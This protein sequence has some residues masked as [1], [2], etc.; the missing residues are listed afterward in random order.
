MSF[1][2][3]SISPEARV[4]VGGGQYEGPTDTNGWQGIQVSV[5]GQGTL[6]RA[7]K[8][9]SGLPGGI[10]KAVR[11]AM[12]RSVSH[13]RAA[14]VKAIRDRYAIAA[15]NVRANENVTVRY[16]YQNGVQATVN[17]AGQ[18]I[19]L[20]RFDGAS[21]KTPAWDGA[22]L[23]QAIVSGRW[24]TVHPGLPASGHVLKSTSPRRFQSA[25]VATMKTG[26]TGIFQ[27]TGG[28]TSSG[29]D[30]LD[31]FYGPSIPQML[32]SE[33]VEERLA[34]ETMEQFDQRLE[35]EVSAILN[36]WR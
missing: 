12:S 35:H 13:L 14:N 33:A 10:N 29:G 21:P 15:A 22:S 2:D 23:V 5:A 28:V 26:H 9:L 3:E 11:G 19:P 31:E 18:K 36:G 8:L 34:K 25:F 20:F 4:H 27:R 6:E 17:F 1:D 7:V 24:R 32:G 30:E 16:T